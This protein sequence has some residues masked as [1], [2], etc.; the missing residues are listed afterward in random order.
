MKGSTAH[1]YTSSH[2][3]WNLCCN[4]CLLVEWIVC[5]TLN[6]IN[7]V[8]LQLVAIY[9]N[10][11]LLFLPWLLKLYLFWLFKVK[12]CQNMNNVFV[13]TYFTEML[14]LAKDG[15]EMHQS[16]HYH[17]TSSSPIP[18]LSMLWISTSSSH[19]L[20]SSSFH[21]HSALLPGVWIWFIVKRLI[22]WLQ[23]SCVLLLVSL[24]INLSLVLMRV[25]HL[26]TLRNEQMLI[27]CSPHSSL[28]LYHGC[29]A[30]L[31]VSA[32]QRM[33]KRW[34]IW[35]NAFIWYLMSS[36]WRSQWLIEIDF[37]AHVFISMHA[38][39]GMPPYNSLANWI[40]SSYVEFNDEQ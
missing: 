11:L 14:R 4:I 15:T 28:Q 35:C 5:V 19:V 21:P 32:L 39:S 34:N 33:L 9:T 30:P 37:L 8:L 20:M 36:S 3:S 10:K 38:K 23:L 40:K 27:I 22:H 16:S 18:Q 26:T 1:I 17:Q 24:P 12:I 31:H 6:W 2:F 7:D 25:C 13:Q 29:L